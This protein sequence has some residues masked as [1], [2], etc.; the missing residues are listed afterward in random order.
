MNRWFLF[1]FCI[2]GIAL[3][4]FRFY[5]WPNE[6]SYLKNIL[7]QLKEQDAV[8]YLEVVDEPDIKNFAIDIVGYIN[9]YC[10]DDNQSCQK[11]DIEKRFKTKIY[12]PR[13][14]FNT[15]ENQSMGM[16]DIKVGDELAIKGKLKLLSEQDKEKE[17]TG[18]EY[19]SSTSTALQ[20]RIEVNNKKNKIFS[21]IKIDKILQIEPRTGFHFKRFLISVRKYIESSIARFIPSPESDLAAGLVVSGKDSLSKEILE[22]FKRVGL[23]HIVVLS[24]SNVSIISQALFSALAFA[25]LLVKTVLGIFFMTC[26][27]IMTGAS[28][29]VVR[30]VFMSS[31][32][33]LLTP[34]LN[35]ITK[36]D[37][38]VITGTSGQMSKSKISIFESN[39][40][41]G[42]LLFVVLIMSII[43]PLYPIHDISFQLSFLATFGLIVLSGPISKRLAFIPQHFGMRAI[44][45][46]SFATQVYI[47]PLL[48]HMS[49]GL[50]I[51]FLIANI[52]VLPLLPI[53]MFFIFLLPFTSFILPILADVIGKVSYILLHFVMRFT[54]T[55]STFPLAVVDYEGLSGTT[56]AVIYI[57]LFIITALFS[58]F[59]QHCE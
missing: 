24:G 11:R 27:A 36:R 43:N 15:I 30:S 33:L 47:G 40:T 57:F 53:L 3:Y 54:H 18:Q 10:F 6:D 9:A 31:A 46:S 45:A 51:V 5:T 37:V 59:P 42:V 56:T 39:A 23:I 50:S 55:L 7:V 19:L 16:E 35:K 52:V 14:K 22:E 26:F 20:K 44:V 2:C 25:P 8:W 34:L 49:G 48:L 21:T 29:P 12:I 17:E 13:S 1:L 38:R 28:P 58:S 41:L 4:V 32:P